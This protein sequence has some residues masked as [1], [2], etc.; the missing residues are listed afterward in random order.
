MGW[1]I[2][3]KDHGQHIVDKV[4]PKPEPKTHRSV[5]HYD[6]A[7]RR[8]Y[9]ATTKKHWYWC[10]ESKFGA[11]PGL[12]LDNDGTISHCPIDEITFNLWKYSDLKH[13]YSK[14]IHFYE[15]KISVYEHEMEKIERH[16]EKGKSENDRKDLNRDILLSERRKIQKD[17]RMRLASGSTDNHTDIIELR[18][19][20]KKLD[21]DLGN[22]KLNKN[23]YIAPWYDEPKGLRPAGAIKRKQDLYAL[24]YKHKKKIKFI[25]KHDLKY[26]ERELV[27]SQFHYRKWK[28][29]KP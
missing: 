3:I 17:L 16:I 15:S 21:K 23:Y 12:D 29:M 2:D 4:R 9:D 24:I 6:T 13:C 8:Y 11:P 28:R 25:K 18:E 1:I 20:L 7:A 26:A 27:R 19:R 22:N 5:T 10:D 14:D